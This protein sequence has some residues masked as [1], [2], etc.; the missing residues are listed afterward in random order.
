[1]DVHLEHPSGSTIVKV[2][3]WV[4][5]SKDDGGSAQPID[6]YVDP[7][8]PIA[9]TYFG[10][11]H[12]TDERRFTSER[13]QLPYLAKFL[14][15]QVELDHLLPAARR[16][17]L[18]S[19]RDRL[20]RTP[21]FFEMRERICAALAEDDELIRL[22]DVRKEELLSRHSDKDRERMRQRFAQL[23]ERLK[24]GVDASTAV[25]A[26][27]RAGVRQAGPEVG[28]PSIRFLLAMSP[29]FC[30]SPTRSGPFPRAWTG[31]H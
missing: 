5:R 14:I 9:Y 1:V 3:Y 24:P 6:A 27:A 29:R 19:T 31:R 21:F 22:N 8:Q 17:L 23:M 13:L 4:V 25:G 2:N 7:Y 28:N 18:S 15:L 10:Q 20:K 12:G 11:T 26:K 30:A 16:E